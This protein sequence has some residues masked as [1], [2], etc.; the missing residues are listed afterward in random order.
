[1]ECPNYEL[2]FVLPIR[3][4]NAV[5]QILR[6]RGDRRAHASTRHVSTWLEIM[7]EKAF[8]NSRVNMFSNTLKLHTKAQT[9]GG[10]PTPRDVDRFWNGSYL[11]RD[12]ELYERSIY[13]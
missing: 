10:R 7:A 11:M 3:P 9:V 5:Q 1:V 4:Q 6:V 8:S 2:G 12:H 13:E